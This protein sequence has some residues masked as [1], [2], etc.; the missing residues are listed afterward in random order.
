M[1]FLY[2]YFLLL[3]LGIIIPIAVHLFNF[4]R[5]K[6]VL[7]TN[8]R[9]LQTMAEQNKKQNK[10]YQRLLLFFR[11][12]TVLLLAL[13]FAQPYIKNEA[14]ELAQSSNNAVV[15]IVDNSF[16]MQ[17]IAY[18]G[19]MLENA[20]LKADE[21]LKEYSD[22][23]VFCLL[24]MDLEGKHK[25]FVTKQTFTE[26]LKD[27]NITSSSKPYSELINVAHH[28]LDMRNEKS[29]RM[30]FISDYQ[31]NSFDIQNI[32][33]DTTIKDVFLPL[34]AKNIDNV[35]VDS[36]S[37]DKNIF[38][39]GQKVDLTVRIT[40]SSKQDKEKQ[41][42]KLF[43]DGK[44]QSLVSTDI[45]A[46]NSVEIPLSFVI[47]KE[48]RMEGRISIMD[49]PVTY[50]DDFYFSINAAQKV[51]VISINKTTPNV[52]INRLFA[53]SD[54]V[55]LNNISVN[56]IDYSL[57]PQ[58]STIILN[59]LDDI[60][61]G[62]AQ[63]IRRLRDNGASIVVIPSEKIDL[64]SYNKALSEM[65]LPTFIAKV[66]KPTKVATLDDKSKL[67]KK[68]FVSVTDNMLLPTSQYYYK[69]SNPT[70]IARQ[71]IMSFVNN[72]AFFVE[73]SHNGSNA[74][75][76]ASP[77]TT[78]ASDF[79]SLDVFVPIMWNIV[80]YST[81]LYRPYLFLNDN[82]FVDLSILSNN[83]EE[84]V[85]IKNR[86]NSESYIPQLLTHNSRR[87]FI[88]NGII[89]KA[90]FYDIYNGDNNIGTLALNYPRTE[91]VL[92]FLNSSEIHK[93]LKN[94]NYKNYSVFNDRKMIKTYF[95]QSKKGL[96]FTF[97]LLILIVL[98]LAM[99]SFMLYKLRK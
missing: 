96:D 33:Q 25:H 85:T 98:S 93:K 95:N 64:N 50:D 41:T 72:D 60:S 24:T 51:K 75:L 83:I 58:Y 70:N 20:K 68:V 35:F 32:R 62:L 47:H 39:K 2:P 34:E 77:F 42:I 73:N 5:F 76:F 80:L 63:Q 23:D 54:E 55:E 19:T 65:L 46:E 79:V 4:H 31:A 45:K 78:E 22:N 7:F 11:C 44:Q 10:L 9:F 18:K 49:S 43:I 87:G 6:R 27:D 59:E 66:D 16:S 30:F 94:S 37:V 52:Y 90:G 3:G 1:S 8:V 81:V 69:I 91:S 48:G 88:L 56:N 26:F 82:S 13:L 15:I 53:K 74:Y 92:R 40:N 97:I 14:D 89:P 21:I 57:L 99:E 36:L 61:L 67:F 28:L 29:K 86:N 17:N 38:L 71:D 84:Y 12:L